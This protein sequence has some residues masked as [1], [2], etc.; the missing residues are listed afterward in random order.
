[1]LECF[2]SSRR[3]RPAQSSAPRR[4][5]CFCNCRRWFSI[6][7]TCTCCCQK[8]LATIV[9]ASVVSNSAVTTAT[10][11]CRSNKAGRILIPFLNHKVN[12]RRVRSTHQRLWCVERTLH[13]FCSI[14]IELESYR[15]QQE[16]LEQAGIPPEQSQRDFQS[17]RQQRTRGRAGRSRRDQGIDTRTPAAAAPNP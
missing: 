9:I 14:E 8:R 7:R 4:I 3:I 17:G 12:Y 10:P 11:R 2:A 15:A 1:M 16:Y 13:N 6:D 5:H